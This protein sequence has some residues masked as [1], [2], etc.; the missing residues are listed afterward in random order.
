MRIITSFMLFVLALMFVGCGGGGGEPTG[1]VE[2][3]VLLPSSLKAKKRSISEIVT[4]R[5]TVTA[6]DISKPIVR[7]LAIDPE[8]HTASDRFIVRAGENRHFLAEAMDD[9][10]NVIYSDSKT[11]NIPAGVVTQVEMRLKPVSG[12][13]EIEAI[14]HEGPPDI[15]FTYVPP[16]GS[17]DNLKGLVTGGVNPGRLAVAVYIKVEGRWWTKPY[18]DR[19]LTPIN[20]DG[21]WECDI[22]TGGIDQQA[23]EI[24]AYLVRAG[25]RPP[26]A[27]Q[28]GLPPDPPTEDVLAM[29]KAIREPKP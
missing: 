24:R 14:I 22:T 27:P 28:E 18:W 12:D 16:Y 23:T 26:L 21:T 7:Q 5:I 29:A 19:P 1:I 15:Q 11:V 6:P 8:T 9:D 20:A 13:V 3:K 10:N 2:L 4:I 25:Y 17:F